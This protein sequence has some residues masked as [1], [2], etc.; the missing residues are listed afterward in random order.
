MFDVIF[1]VPR[2][3]CPAGDTPFSLSELSLNDLRELKVW[4][5]AIL[6]DLSQGAAWDSSR[7]L[8]L[9][10]LSAKVLGHLPDAHHDA[11]VQVFG[12]PETASLLETPD[13]F[14]KVLWRML[15]GNYPDIEAEESDITR[16]FLA[17]FERNCASS[18]KAE[19]LAIAFGL[20]T[21]GQAEGPLTATAGGVGACGP[22][23]WASIVRSL[24]SRYGWDARRLG[25]IPLTQ[26]RTYLAGQPLPQGAGPGDHLS[27]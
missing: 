19:V 6:W 18:D 25:H 22:V 13:G 14:R 24:G 20:A 1:D 23:D 2:L 27:P 8:R 4:A 21:C 3:Y 5:N 9:E 12:D 15:Q 26:L 17:T 10:R 7:R 16:Q 11:I